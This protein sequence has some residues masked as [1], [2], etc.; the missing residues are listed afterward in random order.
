DP[1][2]DWYELVRLCRPDKWQ[3]LRGDALVAMDHR[4]AAEILLRFYEDLEAGNAAPPLE[5]VPKKFF[6]PRRR[7][8]N[9]D[10]QELDRVL[11][12]FGIS[13][14]PSLFLVL[15][16]ETE[17]LLVPRAMEVLGIPRHRS[18][19]Q[20]FKGQGVD[21]DFGLLASH[22]SVP[23]LGEPVGD[24]HLLN[25]PPTHFMVAVDAEKSFLTAE[26]C[27]EERVKWATRIF[28]EVPSEYRT[29]KYSK[30]TGDR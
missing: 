5:P 8:L 6:A 14:Q 12:D 13:P 25:R 19:I 10:P 29:P 22:I 3:K 11:M 4:I 21:T 20:I 16:G 7:R 18:F 9:A 28:E 17:R 2:N 15:E 26:M 23:E 24:G 1:L 30:V 27:E